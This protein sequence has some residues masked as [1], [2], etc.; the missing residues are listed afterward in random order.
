[1]SSIRLFRDISRLH[2][3][4]SRPSAADS[5]ALACYDVGRRSFSH[6]RQLASLLFGSSN[7]RRSA[8]L[9]RFF[10]W[11]L[12]DADLIICS[13]SLQL[14]SHISAELFYQ[15]LSSPNETQLLARLIAI[16]AEPKEKPLN[17]YGHSTSHNRRPCSD[18][19]LGSSR[20][21][22]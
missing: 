20:T 3:F 14:R 11:T 21:T 19:P 13:E 17:E 18:S 4:Q 6:S 8:T 12:L 9:P 22:S 10:A 7:K 5:F 1:M 2:P 16:M 15:L